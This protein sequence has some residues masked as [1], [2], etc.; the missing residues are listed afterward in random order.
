MTQADWNKRGER[1]GGTLFTLTSVRRVGPFA[2]LG[3]E[4]VGRIP[5]NPNQAPWLYYAS[6]TYYLMQLK[7]EWFVI[8]T[9][10][11]IT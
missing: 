1:E 10:G 6:T 7:G 11:W 2:R 9:E 5:R 3:V 8:T 4:S